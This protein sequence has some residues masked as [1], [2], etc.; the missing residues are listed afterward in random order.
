MAE[1]AVQT[2]RFLSFNE[3]AVLTGAGRVSHDNAKRIVHG[4]Y[5]QFDAARRTREAAEADEAELDDLDSLPALE[6][7]ARHPKEQS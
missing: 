1:W 7:R 2:D 5:D 4:R 3:R 6:R